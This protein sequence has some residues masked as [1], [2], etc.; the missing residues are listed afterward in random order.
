ML[1]MFV[2]GVCTQQQLGGKKWVVLVIALF[3]TF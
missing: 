3:A 1:S 2:F